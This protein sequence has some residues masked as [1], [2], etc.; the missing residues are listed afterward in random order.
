MRPRTSDVPLEDRLPRERAPELHALI[1]EV[2][3]AL[4]TP[5]PDVVIVDD[6]HNAF[7]TV[8]GLRRRRVL[9]LGLPLFYPLDPQERIALIAHELGHASNGDSGRGLIVGSALRA[10]AALYELVAP[11]S[12]LL[13]RTWE[14]SLAEPLGNAFMWVVSRPVWWLLLLQAHLLWRDHQR[15]EF[16]ADAL[17]ARVAGTGAVVGLHENLLFASGLRGAAHQAM[18]HDGPEPLDLFGEL[19]RAVR[20]VP[21]HERQRRR[22]VARR[23]AARLDVTHPPMGQRIAVLESR[24]HQAPLVVLDA[25]PAAR[26]DLELEPLRSPLSARIVDRHRS[27]LYYG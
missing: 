19:R 3:G 25:E 4:G 14:I 1:D 12:R 23:E 27:S 18:H 20:D 17:A 5:A 22:R 11:G 21:E 8:A 16:L 24:P 10:L 2:A 15:A 13:A 7:W 6:A 26:I 9:G